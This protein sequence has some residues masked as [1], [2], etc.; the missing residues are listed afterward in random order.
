MLAFF[1]EMPAYRARTVRE[2]S[3]VRTNVQGSTPSV[4]AV[5]TFSPHHPHVLDEFGRNP[6]GA[7]N[8]RW[9]RLP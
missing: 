1:C 2:Y 4:C 6:Y 9:L 8:I 5:E 7:M 3:R